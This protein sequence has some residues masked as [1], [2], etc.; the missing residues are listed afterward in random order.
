MCF[1]CIIFVAEFNNNTVV[2]ASKY[3]TTKNDFHMGEVFAVQCSLY[4]TAFQKCTMC[5]RDIY[6]FLNN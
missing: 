4:I 3:L 1:D 6:L 5:Y 2:V